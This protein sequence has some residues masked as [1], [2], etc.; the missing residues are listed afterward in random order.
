MHANRRGENGTA[1]GIIVIARGLPQKHTRLSRPIRWTGAGTRVPSHRHPANEAGWRWPWT[2]LHACASS[3][4]TTCPIPLCSPS[5]RQLPRTRRSKKETNV[6]HCC[7]KSVVAHGKVCPSTASHPCPFAPA[8]SSLP[9]PSLASRPDRRP[10]VPLHWHHCP[11][12]KCSHGSQHL[13][14]TRPPRQRLAP[15]Q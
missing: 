8:A 10:R 15:V 3:A 7:S 2:L 5:S 13:K 1:P 14:S 4:R 6:I 9:T 12:S 11:T